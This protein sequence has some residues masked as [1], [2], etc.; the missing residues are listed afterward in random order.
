M[1]PNFPTD[2]QEFDSDDRIS[3]SRLDKKFIAVHDDGTEFEFDADSKK[4]TLVEED[5]L[6]VDAQGYGGES[7]TAPV[8]TSGALR[9]NRE[10]RDGSEV[11]LSWCLRKL[12]HNAAR[13][14]PRGLSSARVLTFNLQTEHRAF[15]SCPT[16][17]EAEATAPA[18]TKHGRLCHWPA[19]RCHCRRGPRLIF[20]QGRRDCRRN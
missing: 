2:V 13:A 8:E 17:K 3:F 19:T 4:W 9:R 1:E 5:L 15:R 16:Q 6:D 7:S 11:R 14:S 10:Q 20:S 12:D 18:E